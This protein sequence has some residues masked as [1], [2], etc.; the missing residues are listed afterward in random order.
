MT[1]QS[2]KNITATG[3]VTTG[4]TILYV[5]NNGTTAGSVVLR[6]GGAAGTVKATFPVAA[7]A[8]VDLGA[9]GGMRFPNGLHATLTTTNNISFWIG[10]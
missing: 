9:A 4:D 8:Q 6:D 7:G 10:G 3:D 1:V 2:A 5:I